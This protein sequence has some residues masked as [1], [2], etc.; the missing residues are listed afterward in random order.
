MKLHALITG[1]LYAA[2]FGT[3]WAN[4]PAPATASKGDAAKAQKIVNDVCAACHASDGNSTNPT[5]PS[6]AGQSP[7]YIAKQQIGRAHV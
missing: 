4:T 1:L 2:T 5:Y 3:G 7:E 6:L